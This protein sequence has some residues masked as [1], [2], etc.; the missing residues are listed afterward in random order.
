M[1]KYLYSLIFTL[2]LFIG[3]GTVATA[4]TPTVR[5]FNYDQST[6]LI[7]GTTE[8]NTTININGIAGTVTSDANGYFETPIPES[9]KN[10]KLFLINP[11]GEDNTITY[12][13]NNNEIHSHANDLS[14]KNCPVN[15]QNT[16]TSQSAAQTASDSQPTSQSVEQSVASS[17][18]DQTDE[19]T[20]TTQSSVEDVENTENTEGAVAKNTQSTEQTSSDTSTSSKTND[21][22]SKKSSSH[23]L[24]W[25][26]LGFI[27]III[28][29]WLIYRRN[30]YQRRH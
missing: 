8:P 22:Q 11:E 4:A 9:M 6:H 14:A 1:K 7:S 5:S 30:R 23:F 13:I 17:A 12:H 21:N 18:V 15:N 25:G 19:A 28:I 20:N 26:I 24:L 3:T 16:D 2:T 10:V 27:V 29:G